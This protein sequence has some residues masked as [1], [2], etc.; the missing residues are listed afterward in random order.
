MKV[1]NSDNL[2]VVISCVTFET[3]KVMEPVRHFRAD[4]AYFLHRGGKEP[5]D[6]VL[7]QFGRIVQL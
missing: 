2:R 3:V 4:K 5:Y 7:G 6:A 1:S